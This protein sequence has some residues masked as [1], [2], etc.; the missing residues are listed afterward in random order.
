MYFSAK[1]ARCI[2][3]LDLE[4]K[5][6]SGTSNANADALS[7][8]PTD[9]NAHSVLEITVTAGNVDDGMSNLRAQQREDPQLLA[10]FQYIEDGVLPEDGKQ[11]RQIVS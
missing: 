7:R 2:Q 5:H 9:A 1:L 3:E 6:R 10:L 4:I 11:A 8:N